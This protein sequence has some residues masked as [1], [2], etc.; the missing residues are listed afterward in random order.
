MAHIEQWELLGEIPGVRGQCHE[1]QLGLIKPAEFAKYDIF[2]WFVWLTKKQRPHIAP[3][4]FVDGNYSTINND[5][6]YAI[7]ATP[8]F[9]IL[10]L[11]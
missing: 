10:Q 7:W 8:T 5:V 3:S 2:F 6:F 1:R 11:I 9:T 4:S